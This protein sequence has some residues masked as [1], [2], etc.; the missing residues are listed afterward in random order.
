M[1]FKT[2]NIAYISKQIAFAS[3]TLISQA[4]GNII[5]MNFNSKKE[6]IRNI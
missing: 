3:I 5:I 6:K 4:N 2:K 1:F